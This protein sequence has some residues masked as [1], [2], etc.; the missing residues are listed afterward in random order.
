MTQIL[1]LI[2]VVISCALQKGWHTRMYLASAPPCVFGGQ[3][4]AYNEQVYVVVLWR[5]H[6][7]FETLAF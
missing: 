4:I 3:G 7:I 2:H 1:L 5:T 6:T